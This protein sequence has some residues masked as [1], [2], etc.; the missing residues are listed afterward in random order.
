MSP[1]PPLSLPSP[2]CVFLF[3][4]VTYPLLGLVSVG[5]HLYL[6]PD[7]NGRV[8]QQG[9]VEVMES[10]VIAAVDDG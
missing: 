4:P 9:R 1:S 5:G 3:L 8:Y 7:R 10:C 2:S 6:L